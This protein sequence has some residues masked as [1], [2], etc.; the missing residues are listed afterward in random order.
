MRRTAA[1]ALIS[2]ACFG[3]GGGV[4][5]GAPA[6]DGAGWGDDALLDDPAVR[7]QLEVLADRVM[8]ESATA[9]GRALA[10]D[11][12]PAVRAFLHAH[13]AGLSAA[14]V[15]LAVEPD[16]RRAALD[17]AATLSAQAAVLRSG[18]AVPEAARDH[19]APAVADLAE[20]A[21]ELAASAHGSTR[22][23]EVATAADGW[24]KRGGG[25]APGLVRA[26]DLEAAGGPTGAKGLFTP[27]TE[28]TRQIEEGRLLGERALFLSQRLP[29]LALWQAEAAVWKVLASSEVG[30]ALTGVG[31]AGT[32]LERLATSMDSLP[33]LLDTQRD[34]FLN[35]VDAREGALRDLLEQAE[36]TLASAAALAET[37]SG[38]AGAA[39]EAAASLGET[40]AAAQSLVEVLR[41]PDAPGGAMSLDVGVYTDALRDFRA[42]TEALRETV[43]RA[44]GLH[45]MPRSAIDHAAWRAAQLLVLFFV[46]LAAYR[47][48]SA[49]IGRR[50]ET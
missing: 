15:A 13:Q 18:R 28:A 36:A 29:V 24:A 23:E 49:W 45:E 5:P 32:S 2:L 40:L 39:T 33:I 30:G 43:A 47:W 31:T 8:Q 37:G 1:Y 17:L 12:T 14:A 7:R 4:P 34:A 38:T 22:A 48:G 44:D 20:G 26:A 41:D 46:L 35:A 19:L 25:A 42:A 11:S 9:V 3:C 10:A 6:P 21:V 16:P 50:S 27:L